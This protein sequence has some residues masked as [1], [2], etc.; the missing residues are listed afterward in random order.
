MKH[1]LRKYGPLLLILAVAALLILAPQYAGGRRGAGER[2]PGAPL[3]GQAA[4]PFACR[5]LGGSQIDFPAGYR[6][7]LVLLDFWATWCPPCVAEIPHLAAAYEQLHGRGLE[8]IGISLDQGN[9]SGEQVQRFA[10]ARGMKWEQV[11]EAAAQIAGQYRVVAIP[12]TFLV[13]GD[14]GRLL[15]DSETLYGPELSATIEKYVAAKARRP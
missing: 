9:A 4:P 8:I 5:S 7:K 15:A 12:A 2:P 14:S 3:P 10:R 1:A 6:G 11:F 13:D